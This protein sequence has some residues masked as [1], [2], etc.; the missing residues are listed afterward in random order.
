L[1]RLSATAIVN[2]ELSGDTTMYRHCLLAVLLMVAVAAGQ[3][4][5]TDHFSL[6][7][8]ITSIAL[9]P[10]DKHSFV[11]FAEGG[12]LVFPVREGRTQQFFYFLGH[13]KTVTAGGFLPDGK[14]VA[15][16]S[17]DGS[18]KVWEVDE[19]VKYLQ[20]MQALNGRVKA[21]SPV[22]R[23]TIQAHARGATA[24]A[25]RSDGKELLTGGADG[26]IKVWD[27][28]TGKLTQTIPGAHA[29]GVKA[30]LYRPGG[31]QLISTG[32]D[33]TVRMWDAKTGKA[34][35]KSDALKSA[36]NDLAIT[37]DG[38]KA[39]V[40]CAPL[41]KGGPG[42][43]V[44]LD[45]TTL[46]PDFTIEAHDEAVTSVVFHPKTNHLATG[47]ADKT[48]RV[49][50]LDTRKRVSSADNPEPLRG[51]AITADGKRFATFSATRLRW[52]DGFGAKR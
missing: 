23:M 10:N 32:A 13:R 27:A 31:E 49:W 12:I 7:G 16:A 46:K 15:S 19:C 47:G 36:I 24:L 17:L 30:V 37:S 22:P 26:S 1:N 44:V 51:L 14:L 29:G 18:I 41:K 2:P 6:D 50:D 28:K 5:E 40:A 39:A 52:F 25:V 3:G 34:L 38:K 35:M 45:G 21:P 4:R 8:E 20:Q 11:G 9:D 42:L 43:A 33:K 48:I